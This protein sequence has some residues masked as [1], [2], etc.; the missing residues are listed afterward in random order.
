MKTIPTLPA[1]IA[2]LVLSWGPPAL[3]TPALQLDILGGSY[4]TTSETIISAGDTFTLYAYLLPNRDN[5]LSDTYFISAALT[6]IVNQPPAGDSGPELGTF[7]FAGETVQVSADMD[8][9]TPP[10]DA[11]FPDLT[12]HGIFDTY[13]QEFAFHF[14][15]A[16][17]AAEANTEYHAGEGPQDWTTERKMYYAAFDIN[18]TSLADGYE[19]HFDLYNENLITKKRTANYTIQFAPFSHDAESGGDTPVPEPATMLLF[20]AGL[21]GLAGISRRKK[22]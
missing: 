2:T 19:I 18:T 11:L 14:T 21:A 4:D 5:W 6:P 7:S 22:G 12:G 16:D 15:A 13:Y 8:Y 9:G 10:L 17:F 1:L 20:G 3:A